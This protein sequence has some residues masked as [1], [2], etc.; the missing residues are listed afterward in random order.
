MLTLRKISKEE[1]QSS[2]GSEPKE[3]NSFS[4]Y[5]VSQATYN[6]QWDYCYGCFEGDKL[7]GAIVFTI[8]KRKPV[9]LN[10]QLLFVFEAYRKRGVGAR[11]VKEAWDTALEKTEYIR[12][13]A[14][15]EAKGFYERQG[16]H[17]WGTQRSGCWISM[18]RVEGDKV[19]FDLSDPNIHK[20]LVCNAR[21]CLHGASKEQMEQKLNEIK[22]AAV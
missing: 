15:P 7:L 18:G 17:F 1:F 3:G 10:I 22:Q 2:Q 12:V 14:R 9:T 19:E 16:F 11:L 13:S 20:K 5:F 21:G 4:K 8:T 6:K